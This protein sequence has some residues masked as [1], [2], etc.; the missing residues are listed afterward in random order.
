[1]ININENTAIF[2]DPTVDVADLLNKNNI[3]I[4]DTN[5]YLGLY[6]FSPDYAN[7]ALDCLRK[8]QPNIIVPYTVK[9]EYLKH[10][11]SLFKKRQ[12]IIKNSVED[13]V[14]LI[15]TQRNSL[16]NSCATLITRH[17]PGARSSKP[18]LMKNTTS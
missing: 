9:I 16:K 14:N 3:I 6:R 10:H 8:V 5:V 13:T 11:L 2:S 17:F 18:K 1:M 4:C 15:D 12:D 7:F